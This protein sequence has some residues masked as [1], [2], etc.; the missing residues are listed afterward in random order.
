MFTYSL[1]MDKN[2]NRTLRVTPKDGRRG[3]SIQTN[4]NLPSIHREAMKMKD[5]KIVP[6]SEQIRDI[7]WHVKCYGTARQQAMMPPPAC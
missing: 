6:D 3:F 1:H 7:L 5:G 4:D 2:G